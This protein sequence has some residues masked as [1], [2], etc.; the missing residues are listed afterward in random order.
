MHFLSDQ[1]IERFGRFELLKDYVREKREELEE[2]NASRAAAD[3]DVIPNSR[4]L[5]NLGTLRAYIVNYLRQH[6]KLHQEMT[7][8]VRQLQSGPE[9]LPIEIYTF[10]NDTNWVAYE[11]IQSDIFDHIFAMIP[12]FGLRVFQSPSGGDI[13]RLEGA[14]GRG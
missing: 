10:T 11:G 4:R 3:P 9:G 5:T 12:E 6:P 8:I 7:L 2:Y 14:V 13:E 1:E